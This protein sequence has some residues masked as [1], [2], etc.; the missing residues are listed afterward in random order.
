MK[1]ISPN[2]NYFLKLKLLPQMEIISS[3]ENYLPIG[4][5]ITYPLMKIIYLN[6]IMK[7]LRI[8]VKQT[9][10]SLFYEYVIC[11]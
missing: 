11:M 6:V 2:E 9:N 3:N 7:H 8:G 10:M 5:L 1:I 4:K